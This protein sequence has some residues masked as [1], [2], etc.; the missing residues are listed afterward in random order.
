MSPELS[1]PFPESVM[2]EE[3]DKEVVFTPPPAPQPQPL[4]YERPTDNYIHVEERRILGMKRKWFYGLIVL[5]ILLVSGCA[6]GLGVGLGTRN[7][8]GYVALLF[9]S[10]LIFVSQRDTCDLLKG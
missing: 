4:P 3:G 1:S 10:S 7:N 5:L 9:L 8:S 6:V 2:A